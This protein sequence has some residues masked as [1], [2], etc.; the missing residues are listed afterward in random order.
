MSP[1]GP[2]FSFEAITT[3]WTGFGHDAFCGVGGFGQRM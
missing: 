2:D 1:I 3:S